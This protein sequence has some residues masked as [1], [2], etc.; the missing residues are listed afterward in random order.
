LKPPQH[1]VAEQEILGSI[2]T[3]NNCIV[4][5]SSIITPECFYKKAHKNIY[6]VMLLLFDSQNEVDIITVSDKLNALGILAECGGTHYLTTL[7]KETFSTAKLESHC[8]IV[9]EK[10]KLREIIKH[11]QGY[12]EQ[13]SKN[14][15]SGEILERVSS[16]PVQLIRDNTSDLAWRDVTH[17]VMDLIDS[18]IEMTGIATNIERLN[19]CTGGLQSGDLIILAGRPS[20]GK[21]ALAMQFGQQAARDGHSVGIIS[22]EMRPQDFALRCLANELRIDSRRLKSG[23]LSDVETVKLANHVGLFAEYPIRLKRMTSCTLYDVRAI[24]RMWKRKFNMKL[25]IIDY[26][27]L[28]DLTGG[29]T[30][31]E[32]YGIITKGMKHLSGELDIPVILLSQLSRANEKE[33]RK[34]KLSDLRDSGNIEQDADLVIFVHNPEHDSVNDQE[35]CLLIVAKQR[36][37]PTGT[38]RTMFMK[39][40]AGFENLV[41]E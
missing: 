11:S 15:D 4:N 3:D 21:S 20:H 27:Q 5:V 10:F 38:I 25:L 41:Y 16:L 36:N 39:S 30:T 13:A 6:D 29:S 17:D 14:E 28:M 34:P 33:H 37:G 7:Q 1:T 32:A 2:L 8:N 12:I 18:K 19:K 23:N 35:E 9:L 24:A 40:W 22:L 31:N 26:L